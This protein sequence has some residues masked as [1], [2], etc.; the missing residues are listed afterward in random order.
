MSEAGVSTARQGYVATATA[1][2]AQPETAGPFRELLGAQ[3]QQLA[4]AVRSVHDGLSHRLRGTATVERGEALL[5]RLICR[6]AHL[7]RAQ[8]DGP[9]EIDLVADRDGET[10]TRR[11]GG[12]A[13]MRSRLRACGAM[14]VEEL[15]PLRLMFQLR[16]VDGAV[17]WQ[18]RS[19]SVLGL[20]A[21]A[22]W[23]AMTQARSSESNGRYC[24]EVRVVLPFV[25]AVIAYHGSVD[26]APAD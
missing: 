23:L 20:R 13:P 14:L 19:V 8:R 7:P 2:S 4:P 26:L 3:F 15:G 6:L 12:S 22:R 9:V 16:H 21:P 11:F 1:A 18:L 25:G 17:A 10:W 5:A 24:F